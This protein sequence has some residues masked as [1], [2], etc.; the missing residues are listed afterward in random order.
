M[1]RG[2]KH[3]IIIMIIIKEKER[4]GRQTHFVKLNLRLASK[5]AVSILC[6]AVNTDLCGLEK[7]ST[8]PY[9]LMM[10]KST[11]KE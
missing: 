9:E 8:C 11:Q 2:K 4:N 7:M 5:Q 6:A 10:T 3:D 1:R